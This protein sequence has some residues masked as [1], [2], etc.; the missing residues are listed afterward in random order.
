[1]TISMSGFPA[2]AVAL[3][4]VG[5]HL[6]HQAMAAARNSIGGS[7]KKRVTRDRQHPNNRCALATC[8]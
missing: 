7:L 8:R 3:N 4:V 2:R 5:K 1:M 6:R